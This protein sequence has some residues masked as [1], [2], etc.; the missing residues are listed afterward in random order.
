MS[1]IK[2]DNKRIFLLGFFSDEPKNE[3][4]ELNDFVLFKHWDGN[5]LRWTVDIFTPESYQNMVE[6]EKQP[7]QKERLF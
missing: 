1:K 6:R 3:I 4:K 2:N 7:I 5:N